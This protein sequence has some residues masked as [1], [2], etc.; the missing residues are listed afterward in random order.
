MGMSETV[1]VCVS[2]SELTMTVM[3]LHDDQEAFSISG[4]E[5]GWI[6]KAD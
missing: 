2:V 1:C 3:V 6:E 5:L 4:K